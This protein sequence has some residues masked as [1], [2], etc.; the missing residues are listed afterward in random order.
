[1]FY[2]IGNIFLLLLVYWLYCKY[3]NWS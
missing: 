1:M 2:L 3:K